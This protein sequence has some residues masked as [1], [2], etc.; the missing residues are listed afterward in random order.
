MTKNRKF[1]HMHETNGT[2]KIQLGMTPSF[3]G[4]PKQ[5]IIF[6]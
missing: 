3:K 6:D 2:I 5:R 1:S 4:F